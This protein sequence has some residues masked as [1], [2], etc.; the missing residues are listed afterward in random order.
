MHLGVLSSIAESGILCPE[1]VSNPNRLK[2]SLA[3]CGVCAGLSLLMALPAGAAAPDLRIDSV[4]INKST[5]PGL[6]FR[7]GQKVR[8]DFEAVNHGDGKSR[9]KVPLKWF[10]GAEPNSQ[11]NYISHGTFG[12]INGL[13]PGEVE[14]ETDGRWRLP[15]APGA[16]WLTAVLDDGNGGQKMATTRF[17][18]D[19]VEAPD[20]QIMGMDLPGGTQFEPGESIP[21]RITATNS[22]N[23]KSGR[24]VQVAWYVSTEP[25]GK[26][27]LIGEVDVAERKGLSP[28]Q[29][30]AV[31][32]DSFA[33]SVPGTYWLTAAID[34]ADEHP[35]LSEHN[36]LLTRRIVVG[37]TVVTR[38]T[39]P[40]IV[41]SEEVVRDNHAEASKD[42]VPPPVREETPI[43]L[44]RQPE[45]QKLPPLPEEHEVVAQAQPRFTAIGYAEGQFVFEWEGEG[46]LEIALSPAGPWDPVENAT[47]P[48]TVRTDS[49]H[50]FFRLRVP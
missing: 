13:S 10:Y 33:T 21:I 24:K 48:A 45:A 32:D 6:R 1:V 42:I 40:R 31:G 5:A 37:D 15:Q 38:T 2:K 19:E 11:E 29:E 7:P 17:F 3:R 39:L 44:V 30:K 12:G 9:R 14:I 8:L 46:I 35:E 49:P 28:Q 26:S 43:Q 22:G 34:P 23:K 50:Y 25:S 4:A 41:S 47:S 27:F 20:L 36:N 18:V 16:Y